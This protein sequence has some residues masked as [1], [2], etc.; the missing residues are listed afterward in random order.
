MLIMLMNYFNAEDDD[1]DDDDD[2]EDDDGIVL[3]V[4]VIPAD[5]KKIGYS[6]AADRQWRMTDDHDKMTRRLSS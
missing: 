1:D 4:I 5:K 3:A 2:D 6:N